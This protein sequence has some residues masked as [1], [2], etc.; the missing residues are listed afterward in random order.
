MGFL[1]AAKSAID[2]GVGM[3]GNAVDSVASAANDF[4][5]ERMEFMRGL[6]NLCTEGWK[7]GW[8]EANGGNVSYRLKTDD[9]EACRAAFKTDAAW[10]ELGITCPQ[11]AGEFFAVTGTSKHLRLV[12]G[13][14]AKSVGIVEISPQGDSYRIVWGLSDG[15]APTSELPS[16][17]LIHAVRAEATDYRS[18]ILYHAHPSNVVALTMVLPNCA[19]TI[20]RALWGA[21]TECI[22][23]VPQGLGFVEWKMPGSADIAQATAASMR[24]HPAVIWAH[25]GLFTSGAS[26]QDVF[27]MAH[28]IDKAAGIYLSARAANGGSGDFASTISNENLLQICDELSLDCKREWLE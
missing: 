10:I 9:V 3:A 27:G 26:F 21:M 6:A 18:R 13:A 8:H 2:A 12:E 14:I 5:V 1:D 25:H 19:R 7:M 17:I 15:T 20:T 24:E 16:H 4:G 23:L 11:M 22:M 28:T